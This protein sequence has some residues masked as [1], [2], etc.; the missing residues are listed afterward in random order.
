MENKKGK[1]TKPSKF[2]I[3]WRWPL[4]VLALSICLSFIFGVISQVALTGAG[5]AIS[6]VVILF[7]IGISII[8]DMVGV[9]IT[10]ASYEPFR[11]MAS[12]K[13]R[14]AKESISLIDNREKVASVSADVIGDICG[15]LSGAAGTSITVVLIVR[16][17]GSFW[18][19]MIASAVSA[20]IAGLTIFGKAYCKKYSMLH[21]ERIILILGK[22]ISLFH[23]QRKGKENGSKKEKKSKKGKIEKSDPLKIEHTESNDESS[24]KENMTEQERKEINLADSVKFTKPDF[25]N[26]IINVSASLATFLNCDNKNKTLKVLDETLKKNYKNVV[27]IIFD[28]LG[29]NPLEINLDKSSILRKSVEA[30]LTSVFPATTTNATTLLANSFP[31]EHGMFGW[32]INFEELGKNVDVYLSKDSETGE[33]IEDGFM[34][35]RLPI[36]PFYKD[37]K[38]DYKISNVVPAYWHDGI[39]KNRH[40]CSQIDDYFREIEAICKEEGRQF[41]YCY[42][43]EPDATMHDN[44]VSS[45]EA[46]NLINHINRQI[47]KLSKICKETLFIITADHGQVEIDDYIDIYKDEK[48]YSLLKCPPYL[49][50]RAT[51]FKVKE[52]CEEEFKE[53]F[54]KNYG[55]D[56]QLHKSGELIGKGYF[57]DPSIEGERELLGDYI[58]ICKSHK[59]FIK[60]EDSNRFKG[61]HGSLTEEMFVPLI[62]IEN[63]IQ[64]R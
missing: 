45:K 27:F 26:N 28:G 56:F 44:G 4:I 23:I 57:G 58:A 2:A 13:I 7:F 18:E 60:H 33:P 5:I 54:I 17:A 21:S 36:I 25:N 15:I 48:L 47:E 19:V 11:A 52:G 9:A 35:K 30:E 49:E 8:A 6:V 22:F 64:N 46:K 50:S 31:L 37:A 41:V 61:H 20:I 1:K 39:E 40:I 14:G 12:R 43:P 24:L 34:A 53:L 29:K 62:I 38:T 16:Y 63:K 51:A 3:W 32:S 42:C 10:S 55:E 59:H